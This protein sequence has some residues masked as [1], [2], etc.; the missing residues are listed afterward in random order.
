MNSILTRAKKPFY[1]RKGFWWPVGIILF[2]IIGVLISFKVSP[3]PGAMVVRTVFSFGDKQTQQA[4]ERHVPDKE[5]S[6][7]SNQAYRPNDPDAMLDVYSAPSIKPGQKL[8]T[9]IWTHGGAW[10]SGGKDTKAS[11]FKLLASMGVTV[12]GLNYSLAPEK[13]YPTAVQQLNDAHKYI[14]DNAERFRVDTDRIFLAGDSAGSQLSSQL[15]AII[16]NT[17]YAKEMG[18]TPALKPKELRGT[19]LFCG[20]YKMEGLV[21]PAPELPKIIGWGDDVA[22]WAYTGSRDFSNPSIRQMS[23]FYQVTKDFPATY[24]S[25]G[26]G[27]PLTDAQSKPFADELKNKKV[28]VTTKFFEADHQPSLPH[29]YQFNL[30]NQDG[31]DAL[32]ETIEFVQKHS[33]G[34]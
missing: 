15:A 9:V 1:K 31:Q 28:D 33:Q 17:K 12:V 24:I 27:D 11:Y 20:I 14:K 22:V 34:S 5:I 13:K 30:D 4:L 2:L 23:A 6:V 10:I 18:I 8:P 32:K 3:W 26:N 16:T 29:E 7:I 21:H 19:I 25:G